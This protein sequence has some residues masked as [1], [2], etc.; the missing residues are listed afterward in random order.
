MCAG[1]FALVFVENAEGHAEIDPDRVAGN[2]PSGLAGKFG[3]DGV[4]NFAVGE[5]EA[6]IG[7]G[8]GLGLLIGEVVGS[9]GESEAGN[10]G[11]RGREG[12]AAHGVGDVEIG[13]FLAAAH[14]LLELCFGLVPLEFGLL[15]GGAVLQGGDAGAV[16]F[17][18]GE[19]AALQAGLVGGHDGVKA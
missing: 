4:I 9:A 5:L 14:Q 10:F 17:D 8:A 18:L 19:V 7:A 11:G 3:A 15:D 1:D 6:E 16:E 12:V 13:G 2:A